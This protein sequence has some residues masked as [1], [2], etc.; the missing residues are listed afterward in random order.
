[1]KYKL[2]LYS[3][4]GKPLTESQSNPIRLAANLCKISYYP[5]D[6]ALQEYN[7]LGLF[8]EAIHFEEA[9]TIEAFLLMRSKEEWVVVI[10]GSDDIA[11][12]VARNFRVYPVYENKLGCRVHAGFNHAAKTIWQSV[13]LALTISLYDGVLPRIHFLGHSLGGATAVLCGSYAQEFSKS[14]ITFGAPRC[15]SKELPL[16]CQHVPVIHPS[17]MVP[18]LLTRL[19]GYYSTG[20]NVYV[21]EKGKPLKIRRDRFSTAFWAAAQG[22]LLKAHTIYDYL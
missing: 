20:N 19:S 14:V 12:W 3:H 9:E 6:K 8:G 11:D 22:E 2:E 5:T 4:L 16:L 17:D 13:R 18:R 15:S 1:M 21:V 10:R 7:R